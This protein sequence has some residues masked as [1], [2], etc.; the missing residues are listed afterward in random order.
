MKLKTILFAGA[1][2]MGL[3]LLVACNRQSNSG[4]ATSAV[5]SVVNKN[6][7]AVFSNFWEERLKLFPV[8]ATI[9]GDNRYKDQLSR[10]YF[11]S[12][13]KKHYSFVA[14]AYGTTTPGIYPELKNRNGKHFKILH[15]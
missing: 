3:Y 11:N 15:T 10:F 2:V 5:D 6:L 8:Y 12:P 7:D 14:T 1:S 13:W 4:N 9:N